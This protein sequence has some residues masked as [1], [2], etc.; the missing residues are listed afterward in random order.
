MIKVAT[1]DDIGGLLIMAKEFIEDSD[2]P[3]EYDGEASLN[4][5]MTFIEHPETFV[6]V[7]KEGEIYQGLLMGAVDKEF[8]KE[9]SA[10]ITKF[11]IRAEFRGS[12]LSRK[13]VEAF[14]DEAK[15]AVVIY[16]AATAKMGERVEKMY[17]NLFRKFG[18]ERL[19]QTMVKY[20]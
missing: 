16:T 19:G 13:M 18:Y 12:G 9:Y 11:Y 5:F 10:Y 14:E 3:Y 17:V 15:D 1:E 6:L 2:L 20:V 4:T 8:T 7:A